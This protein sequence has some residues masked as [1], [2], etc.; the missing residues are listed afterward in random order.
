MNFN[1]IDHKIDRRCLISIRGEDEIFEIMKENIQKYNVFL[2]K[3]EG[4]MFLQ[5]YIEKKSFAPRFFSMIKLISTFR[6]TEN[7]YSVMVDITENSGVGIIKELL[8]IRSITLGETYLLGN[9]IYLT[10]RYHHDYSIS[11]TT[12]LIKWID[13][14]ENIRIENIRHSKT[15]IEGMTLLDKSLPLTVIQTS[16][17]M[18]EGHGPLYEIARQYPETVTEVDVRSMSITSIKCLSYAQQ[19]IEILE[20]STVSDRDFIYETIELSGSLMD[21]VLKLNELRIP[22]LAT[23]LELKN[24]RLF[25]T[26][27]VPSEN[28]DEYIG[29][30]SK[31]MKNVSQYDPRI[32]IYSNINEKVWSML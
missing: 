27:I 25:N 6:E 23:I 10:F 28:S 7:Y 31:F 22:R 4:K 13:R 16:T 8:S 20:I 5:V 19:K 11:L 12:K 29:I 18:P 24:G 1:T 3:N 9:R 15:F 21:R 14:K 26:T 30:Y 17:I 32:E 2:Y